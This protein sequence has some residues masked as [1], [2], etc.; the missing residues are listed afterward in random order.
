MVI[1][2]AKRL[3]EHKK[4]VVILLDSITRLAR[5]YN[6]VI[7]SSGKVL[8]GGVDAH[9]LERPKRFFGAARNI[10]EGGS[11][12]IIATSLIDTGSKMDEVIYEEF[13]GTGNLE[14]HL[15]RKIA[16]KRVYPAINIRRSGTRREDLLMR[17]EEMQRVWILRKLLHDMEDTAA[18]EF[19]IER[20]KNFKTNDQFFL[21]MK[22]K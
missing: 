9:A 7:P 22:S 20:L 19:L 11:L 21:S 6:T 4:D 2:R 10:E 14:L 1:E 15:D 18:T 3:V 8:T 16:E 17:D 13:K 12:S 5:A